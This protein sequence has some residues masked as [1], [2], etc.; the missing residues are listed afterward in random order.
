MI[1]QSVI[2]WRVRPTSQLATEF[3]SAVISCPP[4]NQLQI[5]QA[6][7]S[8]NPELDATPFPECRGRHTTRRRVLRRV[9]APASTLL[10]G[11][12]GTPPVRG[13][14]LSLCYKAR[15]STNTRQR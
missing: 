7:R 8:I 1:I 10:E 3:V 13:A 11:P 6:K 9:E 12:T 14:F 5:G 4:A 15:M 2:R